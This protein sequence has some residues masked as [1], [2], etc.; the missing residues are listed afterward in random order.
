MSHI[1]DR[2]LTFLVLP[3][4]LY[5]TEALMV[6]IKETQD[7]CHHALTPVPRRSTLPT[8]TTLFSISYSLTNVYSASQMTFRGSHSSGYKD[9]CLLG[10]RPS[11]LAA[12]YQHHFPCCP[13]SPRIKTRASIVHNIHKQPPLRINAVSEQI[14]VADDN[15]V[16]ISS[17]NF[18]DFCS[19]SNLVLSYTIKWFPANNQT[20]IMNSIVNT[21]T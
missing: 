4:D 7:F 21:N 16:V 8:K 17:R 1:H 13:S 2:T 3:A 11:S 15:S 9:E 18:K 14:L 12:V 19:V 6:K 10:V 5:L 20:N